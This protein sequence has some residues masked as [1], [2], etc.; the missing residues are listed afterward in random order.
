MQMNEIQSYIYGLLVT[1]GTLYLTTRNK[2]RIILE[3][4]YQDKDI[5]EKLCK[6]IP[7]S[8]IS[9][10]T[11]NTNFKKKYHSISFC[12]YRLEFREWLIDCGFPQENKTINACPPVCSYDE[13]GFW[14]GVIDGDGSLG[15]A[16]AGFPF[17][18]FVTKSEQLK[19]AYCDFLFE[20]FNIKKNVHRNK[21]DNVYNLLVYREDAVRLANFLYCGLSHDMYLNRKYDKAVKI[22]KWKR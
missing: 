20:N 12:N 19:Q 7:D 6:V 2:G 14:R 4:Q 9:E 8:R 18:S 5:V 17:I 11:R 13:K 15:F 1:D 22:S 10:R 21:R 3:I 16:S